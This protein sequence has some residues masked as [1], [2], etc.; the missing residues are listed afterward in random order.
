MSYEN[1]CVAE[2]TKV[3]RKESNSAVEVL[4]A[5][6]GA[7]SVAS[8][9]A[10]PRDYEYFVEPA[11]SLRVLHCGRCGCRFLH[12]RPSVGELISFY[13]SDYHAYNEDHGALAA[14]LV[15]LRA[16]TRARKYLGLVRSRPVR[17]FDVGTGDCRH[18]SALSRYGQFQFSGVELKPEMVD[19]ARARGYEVEQGTL[20]ELET[21]EWEGQCDLVTMYQLVEHVCQPQLLLSKAVSLLKPGGYI[22]GQLPCLDSLEQRVFGR[23]WAGFHYPRHLQ[24]LNKRGLRGLL[25]R[26]GF[27]DIIVKP[28][29]HLQ[30][31]L[32]LQNLL[33]G[34]LGYHPAMSYGKTPIY[35]LLLLAVAPFCAFEYLCRQAGMMNFQARKP[36]APEGNRS[37]NWKGVG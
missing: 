17:L 32:S 16:R 24:M 22:L 8:I 37:R 11:R 7:G 15:A 12:P 3:A 19:R 36:V 5:V 26:A 33:I 21:S 20:E 4:C 27:G 29:L 13:P 23:Y 6:C 2:A 9:E 18:F 28:A 10:Q 31:G 35:S 25:E 34:K 1:V 30:A 14:W